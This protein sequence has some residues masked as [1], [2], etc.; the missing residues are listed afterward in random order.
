MIQVLD[1]CNLTCKKV[2]IIMHKLAYHLKFG[3]DIDRV[4]AGANLNIN[5]HNPLSIFLA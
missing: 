3:Q 5:L 1:T 4:K 2:T